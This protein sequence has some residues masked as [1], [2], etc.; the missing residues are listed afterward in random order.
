MQANNELDPADVR[1]PLGCC[2]QNGNGDGALVLYPVIVSFF[3]SCSC[4]L[5]VAE[6]PDLLFPIRG[7]GGQP[8]YLRLKK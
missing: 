5:L 3:F 2:S 1:G 8:F 7:G 6:W 4:C